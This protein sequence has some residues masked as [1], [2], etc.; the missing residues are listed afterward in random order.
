MYVGFR[1]RLYNFVI[2]V[3]AEIPAEIPAEI[4]TEI[5]A[6]NAA[7]NGRRNRCRHRC[8]HRRSNNSYFVNVFQQHATVF[9]NAPF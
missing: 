9:L 5:A 1:F 4:A 7:E 3:H 6:E 8:R 2:S